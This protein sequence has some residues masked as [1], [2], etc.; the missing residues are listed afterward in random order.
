MTFLIVVQVQLSPFPHTTSPNTSHPHFPPLIL[1]PP[2]GFVHVT[3]IDITENLFHLSLHYPIPPPLCLLSVCSQF[4]CL[5]LYF[6]FL[7][8]L[9]IRFHLKV[10]SYGIYLLPPGLFHLAQ[11]SLDS[12][13][14]LQRVG[15][16]SLFLLDDIPL[17]KCIIIF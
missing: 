2:F 8:V 13:I 14:L 10:R 17:C 4:Q 7:F 9:L 1:T 11:C 5:W 3:F 15:A 6:A 12:S 16:P